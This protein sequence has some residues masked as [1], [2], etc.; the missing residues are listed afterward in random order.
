MKFW[1]KRLYR[2]CSDDGVLDLAAQ[3]AFYFLFMLFPFI[4]FSLSIAVYL[5][6]E[7]NQLIDM[8]VGYAPDL[9]KEVVGKNIE[10]IQ[11][12]HKGI[13]SFGILLSLISASSGIHA[14]IRA[15]NRAYNVEE[16]RNYF[17]VRCLAILFTLLMITTISL[18][19][20]VPIINELLYIK[21]NRLI[22]ILLISVTVSL[23]YWFGPNK[24]LRYREVFAGSLFTVVSWQMMSYAFG[25]VI[26][27]FSNLSVAYGS[28]SGIILLMIWFY[29]L[30]LILIIGGEINVVINEWRNHQ[31]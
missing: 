31:K 17:W 14:V 26:K 16:T 18:M 28:L 10:E 15:L 24:R 27:A 9:S 19:V 23:V 2:H 21:G 1:L 30:G 8:I 5:P 29:L 22:G 13:F 12:Q 7:E 4:L 25:Y 20:F 11:Q 6:I 3:L